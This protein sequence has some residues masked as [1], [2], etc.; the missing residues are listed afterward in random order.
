MGEFY[1]LKTLPLRSWTHFAEM[2]AYLSAVP[3]LGLSWDHSEH[4]GIPISVPT[5]IWLEMKAIRLKYN[6]FRFRGIS[7]GSRILPQNIRM[8][9]NLI[10]VMC[11]VCEVMCSF[12]SLCWASVCPRAGLWFCKMYSPCSFSTLSSHGLEVLVEMLYLSKEALSTF[13]N[14]F[15]YLPGNFCLHH[16]FSIS[17]WMTWLHNITN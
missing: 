7:K 11:I 9:G 3:N 13:L 1:S 16:K 6:P 14:L 12:C 2:F 4:S 8:S 5:A 15:P 17:I 10:V